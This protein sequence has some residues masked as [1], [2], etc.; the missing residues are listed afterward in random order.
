MRKLVYFKPFETSIGIVTS[1]L[2]AEHAVPDTWVSKIL[3]KVASIA[4]ITLQI[5]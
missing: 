3:L 5:M 1:S 2:E 4:R